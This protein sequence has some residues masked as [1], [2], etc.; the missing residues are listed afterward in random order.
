MREVMPMPDEPY[1]RIIAA[2]W[3]APAEIR[4]LVTTRCTGFSSAPWDSLN[5]AAHVGDAPAAV[6]ANRRLLVEA[7]RLPSE[8]QW[9]EQVHG[10]A[11]VEA[12]ADG[13]VRTGDG[14]YTDCPGVVCAVLT[15]DCLP[16]VL[17]SAD[18][19]EVA[20]AH[21]GWRGLAAGVLRNAVRRFRA[22]PTTLLAWLGPAI[23]QQAFE[24]GGEVREAFLTGAR[25]AAQ[26]LAVEAAFVPSAAG[27]GKYH[28]DL[29]ALARAELAALGVGTVYGGGFCCYR[30]TKRFFSYRRDGVTGR[31][32]TLAWIDP[33]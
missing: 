3:P 13:V 11:V 33:R 15:A 19:A 14:A 17:G 21:C 32:A 4:A 7:L 1:P 12:A 16:V 20:V 30:D 6:A 26:R 27:P 5:L 9:L 18:G 25:T 2:D 31:M 22:P 29:Y 8:P 24:V 28:A 23:G 10:D